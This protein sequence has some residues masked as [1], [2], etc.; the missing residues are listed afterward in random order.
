MRLL[1]QYIIGR[2][3]AFSN[4]WC[5]SFLSGKALTET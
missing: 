2:R 3:K 5:N 1:D 4:A